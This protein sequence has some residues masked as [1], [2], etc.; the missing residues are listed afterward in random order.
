MVFNHNVVNQILDAIFP[1]PEE[2]GVVAYE[3]DAP[4]LQWEYDLYKRIWTID[5]KA[6]IYYGMSKLVIISPEVGDVVI[7]I[8]FNGSYEYVYKDDYDE[9]DDDNYN[10]DEYEWA[11]FHYAPG[12]DQ[13]DY[14]LAEYEKFQALKTLHLDCFVAKTFLYKVCCGVRVFIQEKVSSIEDCY[15]DHRPSKQSQDLARKIKREKFVSLDTDWL[16]NCLDA[17]K[18]SKLDKFITYCHKV[19][20]NILSDL[21]CG[22][23]GY[24]KNGTPV[25][26][27][28]SDFLG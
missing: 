12:S 14:C 16:A 8:P 24:R 13:S 19:D 25:I 26:L 9:E 23:Y 1:L 17:Y 10:D 7:K 22:N 15:D 18:Q 11:P 4:D 2:F 20:Y 28:Y 6:S 21:H 5:E 27:D 3:N